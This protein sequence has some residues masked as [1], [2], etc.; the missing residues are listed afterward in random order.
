MKNSGAIAAVPLEQERQKAIA[1]AKQAL[2]AYEQQ[3]ASQVAA[4]ERERQQQIAKAEVA[5]ANAEKTLPQRMAAWEQQAR[6]KAAWIPLVASVLT[7]SNNAR[8]TQETDR[9]V[10]VSG[11]NGKAAYVFVA[12][13]SL[14]GV[15][16]LRLEA[17]SDDRL[18]SKGPGRAPNG[19]FVLSQFSVEWHPLNSPQKT[20]RV[21]LQNAQ[22]DF[23]QDD[24][25]VQIAVGGSPD[26]GWAVAPKL[27]QSHTAVFETHD[28]IAGPGVFTIRM[29]QNFPDGQHTLGRF[30][31]SVT[32]APRPVTVG[33]PPANIAEILAVAGDKRTDKQKAAILAHFRSIDVDLKQ[34]GEAL[35]KAGSRCPSIPFL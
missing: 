18:P 20:V 2:E 1:A 25:N 7:A 24:Y 21:V 10:V 19:N 29:D 16:G 12:E 6:N 15:T 3:V 4:Q 22:A 30:R 26:K 17:L 35:A 9:A 32:D 34:C 33:G 27:G 11:P 31:I 23:S 28:N 8:L 14:P 5:L 13:N